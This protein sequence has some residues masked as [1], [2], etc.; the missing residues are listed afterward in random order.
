[1]RCLLARVSGQDLAQEV[2]LGVVLLQNVLI[3]T[4]EIIRKETSKNLESL[5]RHL[6]P[7][8][9][10]QRLA[11]QVELPSENFVYKDKFLNR[12]NQ[13]SQTQILS[14]AAL[15]IKDIPWAVH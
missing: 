2:H 1:M 5:R 4:S 13:G 6:S 7:N 11:D 3:W 8:L 12:L 9:L 10:Q 14:R 15:Y